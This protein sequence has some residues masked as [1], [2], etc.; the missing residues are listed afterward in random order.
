MITKAHSSEYYQI[1]LS[2]DNVHE[3][4]LTDEG[5]RIWAFPHSI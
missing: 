3:G 1:E 5:T 4:S 2:V